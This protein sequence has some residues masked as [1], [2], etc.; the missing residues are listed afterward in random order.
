MIVGRIRDASTFAAGQRSEIGRYEVPTE[1]PLPGFG[2]GKIDEDFHIAGIRQVVTER[3]KRVVM[4]LMAL[5]PRFFK[6]KM[7]SLSGPKALLFLHLLIDLLTRSVVSVCAI[8]KDFLLVSF[9][10][11]WVSLEEVCLPSFDVLNC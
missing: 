4:Y 3:L 10:T 1:V 9:V 7:L 6:W 2:I 11:N 5:G 8:S